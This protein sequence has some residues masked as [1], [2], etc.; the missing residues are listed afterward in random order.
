MKLKPLSLLHRILGYRRTP[1]TYDRARE[2]LA[3]QKAY[4]EVTKA[5]PLKTWRRS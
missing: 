1:M 5:K 2:I 3:A 4:T